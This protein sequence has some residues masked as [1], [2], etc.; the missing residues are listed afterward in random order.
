ME[1]PKPSEADKEFFRSVLPGDPEVEVKPMFGN[2]GAFVHGNMFAGLFGSAVGVR[3]DDAARQELEGIAGSGPFVRAPDGR[4]HQPAR[5]LARDAGSRLELG[6][7]VA[8]PRAHSAAQGQEGQE[9]RPAVG[10]L[11]ALSGPA[12][13]APPAPAGG[14]QAH[15]GPRRGLGPGGPW[16]AAGQSCAVTALTSV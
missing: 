15:P 16:R 7:A 9:E 11:G 3:L 12:A 1:V 2:L 8:V 6:R 4:V 10:L 14:G 5:G 13:P